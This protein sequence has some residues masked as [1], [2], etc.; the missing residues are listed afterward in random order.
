MNFFSRFRKTIQKPKDWN[1]H[2]KSEQY[3]A[4]LYPKGE[5][6]NESFSIGTISI[7]KI[8]GELVK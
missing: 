5:F 1:D 4:S 3:F 2:E 6:K 8:A 7:D